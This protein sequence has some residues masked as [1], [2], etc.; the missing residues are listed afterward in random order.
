MNDIAI[1]NPISGK[2]SI[3][4]SLPGTWTRTCVTAS[5]EG[6]SGGSSASCFGAGGSGPGVVI[7]NLQVKEGG[8][9]YMPN[10]QVL[11]VTGGM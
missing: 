7:R 2:A 9:T 3:R 10:Q 11:V 1:N 4:K 5:C 8:A 6:G